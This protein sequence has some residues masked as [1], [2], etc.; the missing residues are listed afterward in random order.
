M[1]I[2][3]TLSLP[4]LTGPKL[5]AVAGRPGQSCPAGSR[6]LSCRATACQIA[7]SRLA[8]W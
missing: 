5:G 4:R 3:L 7:I 6:S 8:A 1:A 2:A